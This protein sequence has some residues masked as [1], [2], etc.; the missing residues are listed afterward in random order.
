MGR[1]TQPGCEGK[2]GLA[3]VAAVLLTAIGARASGLP[4]GPLSAP[5]WSARPADGAPVRVGLPPHRDR[6][7]PR[8]PRA[9]R[10]ETTVAQPASMRGRPLTFVLPH[11]QGLARLAVDGQEAVALDPP[12]E[13]AH[14]ATRPHRFRVPAEATAD[15]ALELAL[16]IDTR[17][18]RGAW[19][20]GA[21]FLTTAP[22]GGP[23]ATRTSGWN[24]AAAWFALAASVVV[25]LL[26][27]TLFVSMRAHRQPA[28][29]W[30]ALAATCGMAYPAWV[31]GLA[32]P[33]LGPLELP[34]VCVILAGGS[35]AAMFFS[36]AYAGA[37]P[38]LR[39]WWVVL[40]AAACVAFAER[41]SFDPLAVVGPLALGI[42]LANAVA[43]VAF[44]VRTTRER[45]ALP[46]AAYGVALGWP[47]AALVS[48]PDLAALLG[49]GEPAGGFRV[50]CVAIAGLSVYQAVA[51][52]REHLEALAHADDLVSELGERVRLLQAKHG[53]VEVLA[54]EL[55]RQIA[56]RSRE[57]AEKLARGEEAPLA[58]PPPL[59]PGALVEDRYQIVKEL[60][61][62]GMGTVYEVERV[63]DGKH[64]ALKALAGGGAP[65]QRAR[66]AREAELVAAV[67]HPNVVSIV[68]V[69]V[70]D[71][72]YL[73]LVM[74]L[75]VDG[76]TLHDVR[77]RHRDIAWTLGVVAQVAEGLSAIHAKGI[78]H[79]DLKPANVLLSRG[80]D[81]RR[82]TVKI[83]DFG[84]ATLQPDGGRLTE[85]AMLV[86][87]A[88][89]S[90]PPA[91]EIED[92][93]LASV[94]PLEA[95]PPPDDPKAPAPRPLTRTGL[96]FGTPQY[97]PQ[98]LA[99]G[100]KYA[101]R[102]SDVFA[103]GILAFEL[104]TGRR[105]FS[106]GPVAA[107]LEGRPLPVAPKLRK[108]CPTLPSPVAKVLDAALSHDPKARPSAK[109]VAEV[110]EAALGTLPG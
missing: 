22:D 72:G 68:D 23:E 46:L 79:R 108:V 110:L 101:T 39:A 87:K 59:A 102:A 28:H 20:D 74:E 19:L 66:F 80:A 62:G 26:Y 106:E 45:R 53:E 63:T 82:P 14:R 42:V 70:A 17:E 73:F 3:A 16:A 5:I 55:R 51:L 38:P 71:G 9:R 77:R 95:A 78:V 36:R 81:G 25:A 54:E 21:P 109:E 90:L 100:S 43:Q 47:T 11:A 29:G 86:R 104:L 15:G 48:L 31:L 50:A 91:S 57:L 6:A 44:V 35:V 30:F 93:E 24:A 107:R 2:V 10:L 97:M 13:G 83:T 56:A 33:V 37:P 99:Y 65:E 60:G 12:P 92:V 84:I 4:E 103:L 105:P 40:A 8:R 89:G 67:D 88:T 96:V 94:D 85:R 34:I 58:A 27:G 18:P 75:V 69:D 98:E 64:L 41:A 52:T 1:P 7:L 61:T 32:E 49:Q 76:T